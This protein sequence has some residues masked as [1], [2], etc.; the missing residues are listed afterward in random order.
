MY[1]RLDG[2]TSVLLSL[3]HMIGYC[4]TQ[5]TDVE[6]EKNGIYTYTRQP[7]F[8]AARLRAI[9]GKSREDAKKY[10]EEVVKAKK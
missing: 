2:L 7:K 9:F 6:Q 5:L 3:D 1:T 4:Y 8:D 10:V